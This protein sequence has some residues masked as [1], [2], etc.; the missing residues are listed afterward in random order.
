MRSCMALIFPGLEDF[1]ITPLEANACGRP[2]IAFKGGGAL[3]T[4]VPGLNGMFFEEQTVDSLSE[5]LLSFSRKRWNAGR[6]QALA[7]Q[8]SEQRFMEEMYSLVQRLENAEI[9]KNPEQ[10]RQE[11]AASYRI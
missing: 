4:I 6:I 3:D 11:I 7:S 9:K 1:G 8:F 2:V 10:L 5:V